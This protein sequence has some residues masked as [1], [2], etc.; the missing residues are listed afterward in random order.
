MASE[1]LNVTESIKS[2]MSYLNFAELDNDGHIFYSNQLNDREESLWDGHWLQSKLIQRSALYIQYEGVELLTSA[3]ESEDQKMNFIIIYGQIEYVNGTEEQLSPSRQRQI[4][5]RLQSTS[6]LIAVTWP[7]VHCRFSYRPGL[8]FLARPHSAAKTLNF[9]QETSP[10]HTI[11]KSLS[12]LHRPPQF[13]CSADTIGQI[14]HSTYNAF[15]S[16]PSVYVFLHPC[17]CAFAV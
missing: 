5:C 15:W 11:A 2:H 1:V 13:A 7:L 8:G 12:I 10:P 4:V 6:V 14:S 17:P 3:K 9:P 16:W